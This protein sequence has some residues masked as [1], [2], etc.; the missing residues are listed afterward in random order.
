MHVLRVHSGQLKTQK[1]KTG[2]LDVHKVSIW[3][4]QGRGGA[5]VVPRGATAATHLRHPCQMLATAVLLES[6]K[7]QL[8]KTLASPVLVESGPTLLHLRVSHAPLGSIAQQAC[9]AAQLALM[10]STV[11]LART[12]V[13]IVQAVVTVKRMA[14]RA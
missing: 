7:M 2:A 13:L 4:L 5:K 1:L 6:S 14:V 9:Q 11:Q 10:A 8:T 3:M 12:G